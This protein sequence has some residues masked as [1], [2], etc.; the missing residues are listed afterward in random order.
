MKN[1]SNC[2]FSSLKVIHDINFISDD[3]NFDFIFKSASFLIQHFNNEILLK[4]LS[5]LPIFVNMT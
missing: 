5:C 3:F 2:H 4:I 1:K